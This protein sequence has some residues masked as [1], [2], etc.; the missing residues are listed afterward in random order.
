[1]FSPGGVHFCSSNCLKVSNLWSRGQRQRMY[2]R[3]VKQCGRSQLDSTHFSCFV[4]CSFAHFVCL[5]LCNSPFHSG[6][7]RINRGSGEVGI[8]YPFLICKV[9]KVPAFW[10]FIIHC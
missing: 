6:R 1:M 10:T 4:F 3:G 9:V 8:N 2:P 7:N 5:N